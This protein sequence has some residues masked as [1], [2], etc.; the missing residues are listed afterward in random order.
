MKDKEPVKPLIGVGTQ[1]EISGHS[2]VITA[3]TKE[4]V[5]CKVANHTVVMDFDKIVLALQPK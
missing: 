2:A 3:I 4:G 1:L 5:Q